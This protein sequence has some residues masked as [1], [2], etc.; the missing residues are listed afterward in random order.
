M[1]SNILLISGQWQELGL[2]IKLN[3]L[4]VENKSYRQNNSNSFLLRRKDERF[5]WRVNLRLCC[6]I[7]RNAI[8]ACDSSANL[9]Y[10]R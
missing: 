5:F 4:S 6:R 10:I 8:K 3:Q 2:T 9:Y 1:F 7:G